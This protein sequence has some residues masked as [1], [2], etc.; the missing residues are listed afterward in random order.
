V[1]EPATETVQRNRR[2]RRRSDSGAGGW[3]Q[4]RGRPRHRRHGR[5]GREHAHCAAGGRARAAGGGAGPGKTLLVRTL[6]EALDLEFS[7]IQFTPD[8][9][10]ADITGQQ[11]CGEANGEREFQFQAGPIF[12]N[13]ILAD[14]INR[15]TPKTQSAMLEA[16]QE[17]SV[18]VAGA[19]RKLDEPFLVFA[20]Q[21]PIEME[22]TYP[23]PEAQLDRFLLK[24]LVRFPS[25][26][27]L[28]EIMKSNHRR[29]GPA[30]EHGGEQGGDPRALSGG[31]AGL[32]GRARTG[33]RT[34]T[35]AGHPSGQRAGADSVTRFVRYGSSPRGH[36]R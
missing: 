3:P 33:L 36:R 18:T 11:C 13:V 20:T 21:N 24:V 10:P 9:M 27:E 29:C 5:C 8:L 7:R 1:A 12:A 16:M 31:E 4:G 2:E 23:L 28:H 14:E 6:S 22:G 25:L 35:G 19:S 26:G 17:H 34:A 32:G 15:A 30:C